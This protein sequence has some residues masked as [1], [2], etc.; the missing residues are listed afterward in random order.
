MCNQMAAADN[1]TALPLGPVHM[2]QREREERREAGW[3]V[4]KEARGG[5]GRYVRRLHICV[6]MGGG[7][8]DLPVVLRQA[9][10]VS[11]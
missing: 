4:G 3:A 10:A 7:L 5:S 8:V 9:A 6:W 11:V 2:D 1:P